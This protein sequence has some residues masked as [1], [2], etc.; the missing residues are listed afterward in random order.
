MQP[1]AACVGPTSASNAA[2][3]SSSL[4]SRATNEPTTTTSAIRSSPL[5]G[6]A[7]G[8]S[9]RSSPALLDQRLDVVVAGEDVLEVG[10]ALQ[11]RADHG[12][13]LRLVSA[14]DRL[15]R[16]RHLGDGTVGL[17]GAQLVEDP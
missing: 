4:P 16:L 14:G 7:H 13:G 3:A 17:R 12:A 15:E 6:G 5:D 8:T 11:E 2:R 9:C 10:A 1:S